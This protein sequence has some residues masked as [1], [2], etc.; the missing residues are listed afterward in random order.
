MSVST[1]LNA[2]DCAKTAGQDATNNNDTTAVSF[3]MADFN[4]KDLPVVRD[5]DT[6]KTFA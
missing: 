1:Q 5:Q 4:H 2:A 6:L 3:L